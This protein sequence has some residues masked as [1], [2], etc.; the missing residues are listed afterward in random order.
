MI[1]TRA[2][3]EKRGAMT[4]GFP[5]SP[6]CT[7][8]PTFWSSRVHCAAPARSPVPARG[9]TEGNGVSRDAGWQLGFAHPQPG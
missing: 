7:R 6:A 9:G 5:L 4:L 8:A 3:G 1:Y 2:D